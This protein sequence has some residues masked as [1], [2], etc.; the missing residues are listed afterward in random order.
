MSYRSWRRTSNR[1]TARRALRLGTLALAGFAMLCLLSTS[2]AEAGRVVSFKGTS[3]LAFGGTS[4]EPG[5]LLDV[6]TGTFVFDEYSSW[7]P[8][9]DA[10]HLLGDGT[11]V[12]VSTATNMTLGGNFFLGGDVVEW[13][14]TT[15]SAR[16]TRTELGNPNVDAVYLFNEDLANETLLFS[17]T[18]NFTLDGQNFSA[19]QLVLWDGSSASAFADTPPLTGGVALARDIDAVHILSNG[20]V[21]FST[22]A[23][24]ASLPGLADPILAAD[25]VR[26]DPNAGA[27]SIYLE[28]TDLFDGPTTANLDAAT[29]IP[30]PGTA[31]LLGAG[32]LG[33]AAHGRRRRARS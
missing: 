31:A 30:E 16:Y 3:S 18:G 5:D 26:W 33:L 32:L 27:A 6:D 25:L 1:S 15:S 11:S 9:I 14:G 10:G 4:V 8:D 19:D 22:A 20:D 17:S 23:D 2:P 28:G 24:G 7:P 21:V 29:F 13:D 12:L